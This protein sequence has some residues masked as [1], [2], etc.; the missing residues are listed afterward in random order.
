MQKTNEKTIRDAKP[1]QGP[2]EQ[3]TAKQ[4]RREVKRRG[5]IGEAAFLS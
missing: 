4:M 3:N 2:S 1:L 5:E